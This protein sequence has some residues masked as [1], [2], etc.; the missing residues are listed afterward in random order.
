M[1]MM[2]LEQWVY[3]DAVV[4]Q[5]TGCKQLA[6]VFFGYVLLAFGSF[7]TL[8]LRMVIYTCNPSTQEAEAGGLSHGQDQC[9]LNFSWGDINK[10]LLIAGRVPTSGIKE[11]FH[12]V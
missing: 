9:C 6:Y 12:Q 7:R 1:G 11:W 4:F 2:F 10:C 5:V 8:E 3:F